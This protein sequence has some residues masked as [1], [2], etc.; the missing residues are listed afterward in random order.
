MN[1]PIWFVL[2]VNEALR[3]LSTHCPACVSWSAI[4]LKSCNKLILKDLELL[5]H[6]RGLKTGIT[7]AGC[8]HNQDNCSHHWLSS[9]LPGNDSGLCAVAKC[10][11]VILARLNPPDQTRRS[12]CKLAVSLPSRKQ[13]NIGSMCSRCIAN[14]INMVLKFCI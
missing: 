14:A 10:S 7:F 2:V 9:V 6:S 13:V 8:E 4:N 1:K 3:N 12:K 5:R 11:V